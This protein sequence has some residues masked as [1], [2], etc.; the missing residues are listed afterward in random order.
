MKKDKDAAKIYAKLKGTKFITCTLKRIYGIKA[1]TEAIAIRTTNN[2]YGQVLRLLSLI[3][4]KIGSQYLIRSKNL[5]KMLN[6]GGYDKLLRR[7]TE[8]VNNQGIMVLMN[9]DSEFFD[10]ELNFTPLIEG[11][12]TITISKFLT[13]TG[14]VVAIETTSDTEELGK[15]ILIVNNKDYDF[16]KSKVDDVLKYVD[17]KKDTL[18]PMKSSQLKFN[19]YPEVNGESPVNNTLDETVAKLNAEL[20]DD[21]NAPTTTT[22]YE[23]P[24]RVSI[25]GMDDENELP[26]KISTTTKRTPWE[27]TI[28]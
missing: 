14:R 23:V 7:Q 16:T 21:A 19:A 3:P 28:I 8:I 25:W 18:A 27:T 5:K 11:S 20:E 15:F 6:K 10:I 26:N 4:E 9:V 2:N 17:T 1:V 24:S 13:T 12:K 22:T